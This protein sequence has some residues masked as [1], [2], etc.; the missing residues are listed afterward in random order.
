MNGFPGNQK[1]INAQGAKTP[2]GIRRSQLRNRDRNFLE[3]EALL[4]GGALLFS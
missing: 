4:K 1:F 3:L 2:G